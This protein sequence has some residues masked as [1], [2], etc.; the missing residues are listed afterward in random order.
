MDGQ[1]PIPSTQML[2]IRYA[3]DSDIHAITSF[4]ISLCNS[5]GREYDI[6]SIHDIIFKGIDNGIGLVCEDNGI[7][8]GCL[9]VMLYPC[10]FNNSKLEAQEILWYVL[11]EYRKYKVGIKLERSLERLCKE[12]G[13]S[14][15]FMLSPHHEDAEPFDKFFE[16]SGFNKL[17][18]IHTKEF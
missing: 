5:L 2:K 17:E 11:P 6:D 1:L 9:A 8:V 18:T 16:R 10:V 13:V 4:I 12:R 3:V 14:R 15:L 7:V